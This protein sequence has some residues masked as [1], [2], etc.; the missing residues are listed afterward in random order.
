MGS[1]KE[2]MIRFLA[3][4]TLNTTGMT[5]LNACKE[6]ICYQTKTILNTLK[7][8]LKTWPQLSIMRIGGELSEDVSLLQLMADLCSIT[9]ERPQ[10]CGNSSALGCMVT[11]SLPMKTL[12]LDEFCNIL[13][14]PIDTFYP[15]VNPES[16][17]G[18]FFV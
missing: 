2:N 6:S 18:F 15:A 4:L 16:K 8:D 12:S 14:P 13:T 10:V 7:S 5:L 1:N 3:G 9:V 17:K 11:A